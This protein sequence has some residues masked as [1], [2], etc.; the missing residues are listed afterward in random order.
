MVGFLRATLFPDASKKPNVI[1]P[2][3]RS[4]KR[5]NRS[6]RRFVT[7]PPDSTS[8]VCMLI[9]NHARDATSNRSYRRAFSPTQ[10]S[11]DCGSSA[12]AASNDQ[13]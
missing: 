10:K 6:D 7:P 9:V 3:D 12:A 2:F 4:Q 8:V 11:T 1:S 13:S 5:G